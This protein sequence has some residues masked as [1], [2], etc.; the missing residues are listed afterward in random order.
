MY[1]SLPSVIHLLT[2]RTHIRRLIWLLRCRQ[3]PIV[4]EV[5]PSVKLDLLQLNCFSSRSYKQGNPSISGVALLERA[6]RYSPKS[7]SN[8]VS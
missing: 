4:V 3:G 2:R 8:P 7:V 6:L 5:K 1:Q